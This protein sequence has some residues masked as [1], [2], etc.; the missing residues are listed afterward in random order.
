MKKIIVSTFALAALSSSVAFADSDKLSAFQGIDTSAVSATELNQISGEGVL[1][2]LLGATGLLNSLPSINTSLV[3]NGETVLAISS[4]G[5]V[6]QVVNTAD[7]LVD[8]VVTTAVDLVNSLDPSVDIDASISLGGITIN[9]S[10]GTSL[11]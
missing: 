1:V 3:L 5:L 2:Q 6:L 10:I 4:D 11:Q 7:Q 9:P 8:G